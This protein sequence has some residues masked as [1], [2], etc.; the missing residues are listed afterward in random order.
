MIKFKQVSKVYGDC[1][2]DYEVVLDKQYTVREF[3][4]YVLSQKGEWG[5]IQIY[6]PDKSWLD[7]DRYEYR[8]GNLNNYIPNEIMEKKIAFINSRGGWTAMDYVL[9]LEL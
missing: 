3:V 4:S 6:D 1:T 9:K 2:A 5:T 7:Y 8:Y